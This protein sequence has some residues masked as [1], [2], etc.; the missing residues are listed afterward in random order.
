LQTMLRLRAIV[1]THTMPRKKP[2]NWPAFSRKV[3]TNME[4]K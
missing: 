1:W 2:R 3:I 4:D